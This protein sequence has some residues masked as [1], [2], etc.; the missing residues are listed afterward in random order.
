MS[1]EIRPRGEKRRWDE[2]ARRLP[3][4]RPVVGAEIGVWKGDMAKRML[5]RC[6]NLTLYMVDS[7]TAFEPGTR[8]YGSFSTKHVAS[9]ESMDKCLAKAR[10]TTA[11]AGSRAFIVKSDSVA[12]AEGFADGALDF[13]FIDARHT[14]EGCRQDIEAWYPK[15]KRGGLV[16]GHDYAHPDPQFE[17]TRAVDEFFGRKPETGDDYTWFVTKG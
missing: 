17:V 7:W 14:Y 1:V 13:V 5:A 16:C 3:A 11:F 4:D 9:Q 12:A 8:S 15:V 10:E 6:P 2:L